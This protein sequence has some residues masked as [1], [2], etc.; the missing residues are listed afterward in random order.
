MHLALKRINCFGFLSLMR[1]KVGYSSIIVELLDVSRRV[2]IRFF[3]YLETYRISFS[4]KL[5]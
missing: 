2:E 3:L 5:C 1:K 4:M